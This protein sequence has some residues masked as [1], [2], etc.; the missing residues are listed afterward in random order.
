MK[1]VGYPFP[2]E[3]KYKKLK[4]GG[5]YGHKNF[6]LSK[7]AIDFAIPLGTQIIAS[8]DGIVIAGNFNSYSY[9]HPKHIKD[10]PIKTAKWLAEQ[11]TN[12]AILQHSDGTYSEYCHLKREKTKLKSRQKVKKGDLLGHTGRSGIMSQPHLHYNRVKEINGK[13]QSIPTYFE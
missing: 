12:C 5:R 4:T 8:E 3:T 2:Q 6:P 11:T 13:L 9:I 10:I 1:T 7:Y